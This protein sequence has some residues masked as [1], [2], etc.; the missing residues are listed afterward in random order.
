[1]APF[2]TIIKIS[3]TYRH[4][5][6]YRRIVQVLLRYGFGYMVQAL[7]IHVPRGL[8]GADVDDDA[9]VDAS[10]LADA[11]A[12]GMPERL[13]LALI[14]LGP[15]FIKLG[16]LL[17]SRA[18]I[19]PPEY[20]KEFAKLQD[21]VPSFPLEQV[22]EIIRAE[23]GGELESIFSE[24]EP[25]PVGAASIAQGHRARLHDG[26]EVFVKVQRPGIQ[27]DIEIDLEILSYLA[28]QVERYSESLGFLRP[29]DIV[30]EFGRGLRQ[31]LDFSVERSNIARFGRQFAG[32]EGLYVPKVYRQYCSRRVLVMEF[33]HGIPCSNFEALRAGGVDLLKISELGATLLLEQFFEHGFFHGDPHPGNMFVLP[34]NRICYVDFGVMGRITQ[35]ERNDFANLLLEVMSDNNKA[36][37]RT[38]LRLTLS[39][40]EPDAEELER[41]LEALIDC[42]LRGNL[43]DLD[44]P[45]AIQDFYDMCYRQKL[46]LKPHVYLMLKAL[47]YADEMGRR[48]NPD[49]E[50]F[51]QVKPF[52][53][54]LSLKRYHPVSSVRRMLERVADWEGLF[55][56]LPQQSRLLLSQLSRGQLRFN[57][58]IEELGSLQRSLSRSFNRLSTAIVV[59]S[60]LVSSAIV[61]HAGT[62]P[63]VWGMSLFGLLG[64]ILSAIFGGSL[65][66]S[67]FRSGRL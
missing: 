46:C 36:A 51:R 12:L 14:E 13:R 38:L 57:H 39:D 22:R 17:S 16:Q 4:V 24:F 19:I 32:R 25:T 54:R 56:K 52:I 43:S 61:I 2:D 42:H 62:P 45:Q 26:T 48:M 20:T 67:I 1:M 18:D 11:P 9:D 35:E 50:I 7:R 6:R 47:G 3:R 60:M 5:G 40:V 31:E 58:R 41:D 37:V 65:L 59:A 64:L 8:R 27:R 44:V 15:T 29:Q 33:V 23:L 63:K 53:A 66:W 30:E 28:G 10:D 49:Y 21:D 34:E 55:R